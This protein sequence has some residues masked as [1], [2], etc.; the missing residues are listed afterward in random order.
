MGFNPTHKKMI[1]LGMLDLIALLNIICKRGGLRTWMGLSLVNH[2]VI[3]MAMKMR[4]FELFQTHPD[5]HPWLGWFGIPPMTLETLIYIYI[6]NKLQYTYIDI[7]IY[8]YY[9]Y[10]YIHYV[11][12]SRFATRTA[13]TQRIGQR[14]KKRAYLAQPKAD[15]SQTWLSLALSWAE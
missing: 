13:C 1:N 4:V 11:Y 9:M 7:Y 15:W 3:Q 2:D 6:N 8:T 5:G 10:I 14:G 12:S